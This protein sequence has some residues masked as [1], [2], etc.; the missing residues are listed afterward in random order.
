MIKTLRL[1]NYR[2]FRNCE[3][4]LRTLGLLVGCNNAGKS[5]LVEALRVLATLTARYRSLNYHP[6]PSWLNVPKRYDGVSFSLRNMQINFDN[7][8]HLYGKPPATI[9]A[10]FAD[11]S[12][13]SIFLGGVD[14]VHAV[15][16]R[17]NGKI[18]RI[19]DQTTRLKLPAI[20]IM[21][22]VAP[23]QREETILTPAY[24]RSAMSSQLAPLHF[25]NQLNLR[26]DL[27]GRFQEVVEETWPHVKVLELEGQ[28]G[29]PTKPLYLHV[30]VDDFVGE[31]AAMGHGLQMWLQTMWFLTRSEGSTTVILDEPDVYLHADL[32]RRLIRYIR[33]RFPQVVV[34]T[35]STEII[36][37]VDPDQILIVDKSR[38]KSTFAT[39]L[40]AVQRLIDSVGSVHNIHLAKMWHARRLIL[41]EGKDLKILKHFQNRLFPTSNEPFDTIPNMSI[42]GWGGW[43]YAIGSKMLLKNAV[44]ESIITYCILDSDYHTQDDIELRY[45]EATDRAIQLHIWSMKEMENF[46]LVPKVIHRLIK[47]RIAKRTIG[48]SLK[49]IH[50]SVLEKASALEDESFD[51]LSTE[52]L[53]RNRS[54]G[55]GGANKLARKI[56][57]DKKTLPNGLL[58][59][60]SGKTLISRLSDWSQTEFGV[61]FNSLTIAKEMLWDEIPAEIRAVVSAVEQ[62]DA[63]L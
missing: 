10:T 29:L 2:G 16:T 31:I 63:F 21:P 40:P 20:S 3:I 30:R 37:E 23:V 7:I 52:L 47:A 4:P 1:E 53:A 15:V 44:D 62:G 57:K 60:V 6:P 38:S 25:R 35:H 24:V 43:Q 61:S 32:Q 58:S 54:L 5:T 28:G 48:P 50:S 39:S 9:S 36:S 45:S 59:V 49:E 12:S 56:L 46:L 11:N 19:R 27:F 14:K 42:G 51:A 55:A 34:T 41:I 8:Y 33:G 18:A 22:Q 13:V 17:P 26:Y